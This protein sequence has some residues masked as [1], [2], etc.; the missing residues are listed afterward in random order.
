M[1]RHGRRDSCHAPIR[2]AL[3]ACGLKVHDLGDVGHDLPDLMTGR[4]GV[5]YLLECKDPKTGKERPGQ[6]DARIAW[7]AKGGGPWVVV[8]TVAEAL[9]AV[10]LPIAI[11]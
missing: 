6:K 2:E 10:G 4:H 9:A 7:L 5:T 8:H 11:G 3:R 1:V